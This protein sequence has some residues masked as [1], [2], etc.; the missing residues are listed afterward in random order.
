[1]KAPSYQIRVSVD[2]NYLPVN[3]LGFNLQKDPYPGGHRYKLRISNFKAGKYTSVPLG[4]YEQPDRNVCASISMLVSRR[5][6]ETELSQELTPEITF[7]A[8]TI[9][10]LI[11]DVDELY[12]EG[13]CSPVIKKRV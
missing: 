6:E 5:L 3:S 10:T 8:N 1:M 9:E 12:V 4:V 13:I 11:I 2:D 7:L